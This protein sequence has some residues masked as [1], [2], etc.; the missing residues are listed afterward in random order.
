MRGPQPSVFRKLS[1]FIEVLRDADIPVSTSETMDMFKA[2]DH[3]SLS[4]MEGFKQ[5]LKTT[6]IKDYTDIPLFDQCFERYF[7][8]PSRETGIEQEEGSEHRIAPEEYLI[9]E[10]LVS[11]LADEL[12]GRTDL[13]LMIEN[14]LNAILGGEG[15]LPSDGLSSA[16]VSILH[17]MEQL[18]EK[19][20][21]L[22]KGSAE[23]REAFV[24]EVV[25]EA[26]EKGD[27]GKNVRKR[28][29]YLLQKYIYR[30]TR[31]EIE[32]TEDILRRLGQ[33]L[34][35]RISLRKRR[36][37]RGGLDIKRT[38]RQSTGTGGLPFRIYHRDRKIMRPQLTALCDVS[39]SVNIYSRFM[40]LLTSILQN[41]FSRVRTFAFISS[42]VEITDLFRETAP[43]TAINSI[44]TDEEFTYGWG[45]N[46][47]KSFREFLENYSDSLTSR[48][49]V[50]V[51]GD[52]RNNY[53]D[54]GLKYLEEIELR[55]REIIWLNPEKMSLWDWGD[56]ISSLYK[57]YCREMKE[58]N[59]LLDLSDF[60]NDLFL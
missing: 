49:T 25:N 38:L 43:E 21:P 9:L 47:G 30:L 7:Y 37:K 44:F 60:I 12:K 34:K 57:P 18:L 29:E 48:T 42:M 50:L 54:P 19:S 8:S 20:L 26:A 23:E 24:R 35:N 13:S 1:G 46:Y 59:N 27:A 11:E 56:S 45:S 51:L 22:F 5:A 40:L 17:D 4:Q 36:V 14:M 32:E 31:E 15:L 41:L 58:V 52:A 10:E 33:K 28:E 55:S 53:Q 39:G 16:A 2:L 3:V 6:L